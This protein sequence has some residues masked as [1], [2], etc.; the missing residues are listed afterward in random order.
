MRNQDLARM[1][2]LISSVTPLYAGRAYCHRCALFSF[3]NPKSRISC[4]Q[5]DLRKQ[6]FIRGNHE[7]QYRAHPAPLQL[8]H[9][10]VPRPHPGPH[11]AVPSKC[12]LQPKTLLKISA[13]AQCHPPQ[14]Y[15]VACR[16]QSARRYVTLRS[17][18]ARARFGNEC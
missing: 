10:R 16:A 15:Y 9:P 14:F 13:S 1:Q 7:P 6:W 11:E 12:V 18:C 2:L 4:D 8:C 3:H 5:S 17:G